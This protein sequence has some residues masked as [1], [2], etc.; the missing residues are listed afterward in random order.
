MASR[1][2][3]PPQKVKKVDSVAAPSGNGKKKRIGKV[4]VSPDVLAQCD[5]GFFLCEPLCL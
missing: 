2:A 5:I 3:R 1:Q 4:H